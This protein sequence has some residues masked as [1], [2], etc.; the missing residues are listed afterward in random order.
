M[1]VQ[2]VKVVCT[3][4]LSDSNLIHKTTNTHPIT[5]PHTLRQWEQPVFLM[6]F[7]AV[8]GLS[9]ISLWGLVLELGALWTTPPYWGER[10]EARNAERREKIS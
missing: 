1:C 10:E 2:Q 3:G 7:L 8:M 9:I 5:H 4:W 6:D